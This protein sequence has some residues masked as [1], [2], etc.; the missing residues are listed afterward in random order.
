MMGQLVS[1]NI[2]LTQKPSANLK[3]RAGRLQRPAT[4]RSQPGDKHALKLFETYNICREV[5]CF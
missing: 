1:G 3:E 4:L 5:C 2:D